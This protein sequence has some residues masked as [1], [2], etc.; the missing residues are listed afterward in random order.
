M[1]QFYA[2]TEDVIKS[3]HS[4]LTS[5]VASG[6]TSIPVKNTAQF[7]VNKYLC[8]SAEGNE[9]AELKLISEIDADAKTITVSSVTRFTHYKDE[10]VTQFDYNQRLLYKYDSV[11]QT[12]IQVAGESP[13]DIAVDCPLGTL[14]EDSNG[15]AG[16]KYKATY[17]NEETTQGTSLDDSEEVIGT[18]STNLVSIEIIRREAGFR[19]NFAISDARI[20]EAR[21][22][23]QGEVWAALHRKYTF[24]LT[25]KS[26]FLRRI[27]TDL[28]VG[29]LFIG[30]YGAEVQNMARDGYKRL[31]DARVRLDKLAKGFYTLYDEEEEEEQT[32]ADR[33]T[34]SF[35]PD[36]STEDTDS[37]RMFSVED[38]F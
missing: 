30:E 19:D 24:P 32:L 35:Y 33:G 29:W 25:R 15:V 22:E 36:D 10:S 12:Y 5:D 11:T 2:P 17:Y 20:D 1:R 31:E 16:D 34:I 3:A 14:L 13:K 26:S 8:I 21:V 23:A 6:A 38:K 27:V 37:E 9:R 4:V 18:G 7:E 28:A